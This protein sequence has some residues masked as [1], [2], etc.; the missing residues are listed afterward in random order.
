M[1]KVVTLD[2]GP[3]F[4]GSAVEVDGEKVCTLTPSALTDTHIQGRI[5]ELMAGQGTDCR[6]CRGCQVGQARP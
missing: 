6:K 1:V 4:L 2:L 5:R 3:A